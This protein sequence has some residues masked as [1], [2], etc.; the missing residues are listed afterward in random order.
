MVGIFIENVSRNARAFSWCYTYTHAHIVG[1]TQICWVIC[2]NVGQEY[3]F[4]KP[5]GVIPNTNIILVIDKF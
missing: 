4:I 5:T 1:E 2:P 3:V